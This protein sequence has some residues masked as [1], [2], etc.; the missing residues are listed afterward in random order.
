MGMS[1]LRGGGTIII[2]VNKNCV[3]I[4][5]VDKHVETYDRDEMQE[6]VNKYAEPA[7]NLNVRQIP[8][9]DK[10]FITIVIKEF[11]EFPV[12]CKKNSGTVLREGAIYTRPLRKVETSEVKSEP[13]MR[14]IIEMA[15]EKGV[16]NFSERLARFDIPLSKI[17]RE[18]DEKGFVSQ[19][20]SLELPDAPEFVKKRP[21]WRVLI[22]PFP[23]RKDRLNELSKC[24]ETLQSCQVATPKGWRFPKM[25]GEMRQAG[26]DYIFSSPEYGESYYWALFQSGQ[27]LYIS[28]FVEDFDP[29]LV[30]KARSQFYSMPE[31]FTPSGRIEILWTLYIITNIF[32]F[33]A[34]LVERGIFDSTV[35]IRIEMNQIKDRIL[36]W[37]DHWHWRFFY[38]V[39]VP[40][41]D[42]EWKLSAD[43]LLGNSAEISLKATKWFLERFSSYDPPDELLA[44]EQKKHLHGNN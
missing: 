28:Q 39:R 7:V 33:A 17:A 6:F 22:K 23:F 2:G 37:R 10:T 30:N 26:N 44:E 9:D 32:H 8:W 36:W 12:V 42:N 5:M 19:L 27:F 18:S 34:R 21:H 16:R 14:L 11:D 29:D 13:E 3:P 4:G 41:L 43:Q 40:N 24:W 1:N 38:P 35:S 20:K 25:Y 15:T 31:D